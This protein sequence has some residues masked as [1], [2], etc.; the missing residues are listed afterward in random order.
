M[1]DGT[2]H[3]LENCQAC[4][5]DGRDPKFV[6]V[7]SGENTYVFNWNFVKYVQKIEEEENNG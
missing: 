7:V 3:D 4:F 5:A 1:V 6:K 2:R